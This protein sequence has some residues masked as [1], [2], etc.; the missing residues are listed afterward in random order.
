VAYLTW[1]LQQTA[2]AQLKALSDRDLKD[3]GVRRCE[4]ESVVKGGLKRECAFK[5]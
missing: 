3:I 4:I 5:S 2:I 1:R